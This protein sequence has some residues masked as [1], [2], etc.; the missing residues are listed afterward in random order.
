MKT[1]TIQVTT[2][3]AVGLIAGIVGT[4]VTGNLLT[5]AAIGVSYLTV[6]ALVAMALSDYRSA[7]KAYFAAP[8]V[9][10]HFQRAVKSSVA[11]RAPGAKPRLAA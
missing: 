6:A 2:T 7:P 1:N 11:V 4:E 3:V 10:G 5:G 8:V 9:T